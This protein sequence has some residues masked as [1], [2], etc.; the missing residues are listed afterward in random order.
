MEYHTDQRYMDA[1]GYMRKRAFHVLK[2]LEQPW[3]LSGEKKVQK[4][5]LFNINSLNLNLEPQDLRSKK[6]IFRGPLHKNF[7]KIW[8]SDLVV[9]IIVVAQCVTGYCAT[10]RIQ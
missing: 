5:N 6:F 1:V 4:K 3:F 10:P 9:A 2:S 7:L 8:A